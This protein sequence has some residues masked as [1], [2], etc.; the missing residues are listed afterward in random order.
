MSSPTQRAP[1]ARP[2]AAHRARSVATEAADRAGVSV[3]PVTTLDQ[4][5]DVSRVFDAIWGTTDGAGHLPAEVLRAQIHAGNYAA[6]ASLEG[7]IIG[8]VVGFLGL[9]ASTTVYLHSHILGVDAARHGGSVG[10]ALKQ[11]QR[12]W[13]LERGIDTVTWTFDPLVRRNAHFNLNKLGA[14]AATY[15]DNFYGVMPD[16]INAGDETDRLLISW[17]LLSERTERAAHGGSIESTYDVDPTM[18]ALDEDPNGAPKMASAVGQTLLCR[19]PTDIVDLRKRDARL[20]GDW[21]KALRDVLGGAMKDGYR[22][23]GF[24]RYGWYVLERAG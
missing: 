19:A 13:C 7:T 18:V 16:A 11:D 4:I 1:Q 3:E 14:N 9:E 17:P 20:A 12:A 24:T 22:V 5:A 15:L 21:R 8:G 6:C 23:A 10:F 2:E